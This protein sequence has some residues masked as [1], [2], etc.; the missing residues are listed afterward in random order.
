[1]LSERLGISVAEVK[2]LFKKERLTLHHSEDL[3]T[4]QAVPTAIHSKTVH[5]GG[6]SLAKAKRLGK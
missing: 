6:H 1:M 3:Q 5:T 4:L 2:E